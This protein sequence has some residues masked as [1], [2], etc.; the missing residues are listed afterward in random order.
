MGNV[1]VVLQNS[2]L[3]NCEELF[4]QLERN[5]VNTY[6]EEGGTKIPVSIAKGFV[7]FDPGRDMHFADV[8]KRA[9][10]AMYEN[11]RK[12]KEI[13]FEIECDDKIYNKVLSKYIVTILKLL[14]KSGYINIIYPDMV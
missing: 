11:K 7:R 5:C 10:D 2:D 9:D 3:E 6:V 14:T 12:S 4:A 1:L 8:F 13:T